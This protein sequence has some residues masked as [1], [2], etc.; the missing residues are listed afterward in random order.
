MWGIPSFVMFCFVSFLKF[1][2]PIGLHSSCST[3]LMAGGDCKN[4][5][6][7]IVSEGTPHS[8]DGLPLEDD[9]AAHEKRIEFAIVRNNES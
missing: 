1:R 5:L 4:A 7:N 9:G 2:L 6:K 3:S 8:V